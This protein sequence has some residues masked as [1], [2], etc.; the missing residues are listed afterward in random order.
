MEGEE[1]RTNRTTYRSDFHYYRFRLRVF[2]SSFLALIAVLFVVGCLVI[3]VFNSSI[4]FPKNYDLAEGDMRVITVSTTFCE[5]IKL[6]ESK[7]PRSL[8]IVTD[9]RNVKAPRVGNVTLDVFIPPYKYWY[10]AFY[11][12]AGSQINVQAN[13]ASSFQLL[14]FKGKTNFD[15]WIVQ[16]RESKI[17]KNVKNKRM[18]I[19]YMYQVTQDDNYYLLFQR[20]SGYPRVVNISLSLSISRRVFDVSDPVF[21][22]QAEAG[23]GCD[24]RLLFNSNERGIV[25]IS[26]KSNKYLYINNIQTTWHCQ[27]RIWFF[28]VVFGGGYIVCIVCCLIIYGLLLNSKSE[29][30]KTKARKQSVRS[31]SSFNGSYRERSPSTKSKRTSREMSSTLPTRSVSR[32]GSHKKRPLSANG[33]LKHK[34]H[35][36]TLP[37]VI[38]H[39]YKGD[40]SGSEHEEHGNDDL[41]SLHHLHRAPSLENISLASF[42]TTISLPVT[43]STFNRRRDD[44][45]SVSCHSFRHDVNHRP[46]RHR[47]RHHPRFHA[48]LRRE[49]EIQRVLENARGITAHQSDSQLTRARNMTLPARLSRDGRAARDF[50]RDLEA[51]RLNSDSD[52]P[53]SPNKIPVNEQNTTASIM[54]KRDFFRDLEAAQKADLH[55]RH[56]SDS[57]LDRKVQ[58][59]PTRGNSKR[60]FYRD[61]ELARRRDGNYNYQ[62]LHSDDDSSHGL[63]SDFEKEFE[64]AIERHDKKRLISSRGTKPLAQMVDDCDQISV[65]E[66]LDRIAY[67]EDKRYQRKPRHYSNGCPPQVE[68]LIKARPVQEHEDH[69]VVIEAK[70]LPDGKVINEKKP[71]SSSKRDVKLRS[72]SSRHKERFWS[73]RLSIVSEI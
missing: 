67:T 26:D 19:N 64:R 22:C 10:K 53:Q 14:I 56:S 18:R 36:T 8:T 50:Y 44:V 69:L 3:Q 70:A 71:K 38:P 32:A 35:E 60:D 66:Q 48:E 6:H 29:Q 5:G 15:E 46:F 51:A 45:D 27:P 11:I 13:S 30:L 52:Q 59:L 21:E 49:R 7:L 31:Q 47:D 34:Q 12:M 1:H 65:G 39:I 33:S 63:D 17:N 72:H 25:A 55:E 68:P 28:I 73:P 61:L 40:S 58:T 62:R 20:I 57:Q 23:K 16:E 42:D 37:S 24:V 41:E 2:I 43:F 4:L 9:V 54:E